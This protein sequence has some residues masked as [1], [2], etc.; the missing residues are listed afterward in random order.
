MLS[1]GPLVLIS[2]PETIAEILPAILLLNYLCLLFIGICRINF[3][4]NCATSENYRDINKEPF[5][6]IH[7][8]ICNE[9]PQVVLQTLEAIKNLN[10]SNY[11]VIIISNNTTNENSWRPIEAFASS[12]NNLFKFWHFDRI[13]GNK[14]GA[15]NVAL[16]KTSKFADYI[17]TVDADYE[18]GSDALNV[19]V[20][21]IIHSKVDLLQFPQ[22][23]RNICNNTEG[24]SVHYKHYFE[25]YLSSKNIQNSALPTGTLSLIKFEIFKNGMRW[26]M[27]T[28]TED[29]H[30][31]I[32]L[33]S[34]QYTIGYCNVSIGLGTMPTT[35][36]DYNKQLRRWIFG[37]FHTLVLM[38]GKRDILLSKKIHLFTMLSAWINLLAI[39]IV[40]TFIIIGF[41]IL[42]Y[43]EWLWSLTMIIISLLTHISVQYY[44]LLVTSKFSFKKALK[45]LLIHISTIE[46][47]SF[48]W[49]SYFKNRNRPFVRTNKFLTASTI[50]KGFFLLPTLLFI[51][52]IV[53]L[54]L[55][56]RII[57]IIF[58]SISLIGIFGKLFL[59][60]EIF[61]SRFNFFKPKPI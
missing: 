55:E 50:P 10:Y 30:F 43:T 28:I 34:N 38:M 9:P 16:E 35:V 3:V 12:Q 61:H 19:A 20:S 27:V 48:Y 42:G 32:E 37:N 59:I 5:I 57:G 51:I 17:F 1:T 18:L 24:L 21:S 23:Y 41:Y 58:L 40:S 2:I 4:K 15:L 22:D 54:L 14:A 46:I 7:L 56:Q 39:P 6:S 33:I 31:G 26:P 36:N 45:A 44:I 53:S 47:G 11:E 13:D 49:L 60:N 25:C 52:S 29:A 8:A